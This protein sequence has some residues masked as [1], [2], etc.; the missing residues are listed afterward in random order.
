MV[1]LYVFYMAISQNP[2]LAIPLV[3]P[4]LFGAVAGSKNRLKELR[5]E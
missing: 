5:V 2:G 3:P 1:V 4:L